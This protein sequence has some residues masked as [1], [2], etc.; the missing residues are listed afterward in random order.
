MS[1]SI[2]KV[3]TGYLT[4]PEEDWEEFTEMVRGKDHT[5]NIWD[6]DLKFDDI[7]AVEKYVPRFVSESDY[8][9][10]VNYCDEVEFRV[11]W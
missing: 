3:T 1:C 5:V 10:L 6:G 2:P 9:D 11:D 7:S 4:I 8:Q